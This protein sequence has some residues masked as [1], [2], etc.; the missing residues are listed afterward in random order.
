[1][2]ILILPFYNLLLVDALFRLVLYNQR[3]NMNIGKAYRSAQLCDLIG[4][5]E[6]SAEQQDVC[7]TQMPLVHRKK[8]LF[9][10]CQRVTY[11]R[12]FF[13]MLS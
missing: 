1:M 2:H 5:H 11:A 8:S 4:Q 9:E 6:L 10:L 12:M 7:E 3:T 13:K